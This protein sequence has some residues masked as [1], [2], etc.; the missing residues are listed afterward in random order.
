M[1]QVRSTNIQI[2][3]QLVGDITRNIYH[4][5]KISTSYFYSN[6]LMIWHVYVQNLTCF[7]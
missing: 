3:L 5:I 6:Y 7:T 1:F 2:Q 4:K